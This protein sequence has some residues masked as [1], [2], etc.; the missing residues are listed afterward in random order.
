MLGESL[1]VSGE[2]DAGNVD[3]LRVAF[4]KVTRRAD[5]NFVVDLTGATYIDSAA[6][7]VLAEHLHRSP[8][9]VVTAGSIVDRVLTITGIDQQT[10]VTRIQA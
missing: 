10:S 3:E 8:R 6:L 4:E 7:A 2:I 5:R 9:C 1:H